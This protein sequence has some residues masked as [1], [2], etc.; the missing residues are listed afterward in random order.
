[1]TAGEV[2][3]FSGAEQPQ[4][5]PDD[6]QLYGHSPALALRFVGIQAAKK[7]GMEAVKVRDTQLPKADD[8]HRGGPAESTGQQ[9]TR[10][11]VG[12]R[13]EHQDHRGCAIT[14]RTD[15]ARR[16]GEWN[17]ES[18]TYIPRTHCSRVLATAPC[19]RGA[20]LLRL[21]GSVTGKTRRM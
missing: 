14:V 15:V 2:T 10:A 20:A 7:A 18:A 4:A 12:P 17:N 9:W 19:F 6:R 3:L 8:V 16:T 1:M 13:R 11:P 21:D 5:A